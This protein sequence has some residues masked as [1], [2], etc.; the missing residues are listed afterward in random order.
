MGR[1]WR[2]GERP[3]KGLETCGCGGS[4]VRLSP[5]KL[6]RTPDWQAGSQAPCRRPQASGPVGVVQ[7]ALGGYSSLRKRQ[8]PGSTCLGPGPQGFG[9]TE[10]GGQEKMGIKASSPAVTGDRTVLS[11]PVLAPG[12]VV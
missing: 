3:G 8:N 5:Q 10:P 7:E 6:Y 12:L 4:Q 9:V 2:G 11:S 1:G